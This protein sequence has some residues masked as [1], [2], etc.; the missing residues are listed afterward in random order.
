[1]KDYTRITGQV[2]EITAMLR[3]HRID[4]Y[5]LGSLDG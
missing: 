3:T 5:Q 2:Y 4:Q 1:M